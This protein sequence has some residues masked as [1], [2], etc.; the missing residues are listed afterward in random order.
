MS[1][2]SVASA[3]CASFALAL[4]ALATGSETTAGSWAA[5]A[6]MITP[7]AHVTATRLAN[8]R[9]LVVGGA[10]VSTAELYDPPT[11][12]W[13]PAGTLSEPRGLHVAVRLADGRVLVVGGGRYSAGAELYNAAINRW[14][15]TGSMNVD[16]LPFTG[17][18]LRD[19]R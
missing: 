8:G 11:G 14:T 17:T 4:P 9:V 19:R 7:R 12:T 10:D 6:S 15:P 16:R 1:I 13:L 5:T 2:R 18:L 3:I